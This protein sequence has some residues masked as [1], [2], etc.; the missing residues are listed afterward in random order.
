MKRRGEY[1]PAVCAAAREERTASLPPVE[2]RR[3]VV[4]GTLLGGVGWGQAGAAL[5]AKK[6]LVA[7]VDGATLMLTAEAIAARE[8]AAIAAQEPDPEVRSPCL[9]QC[10][11]YTARKEPE[12]GGVQGIRCCSGR[13][14]AKTSASDE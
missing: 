13:Q 9:P 6:P 11:A 2:R 3:V 12:G 1:D 14:D 10:V 5:A 4:L 7:E 8:A